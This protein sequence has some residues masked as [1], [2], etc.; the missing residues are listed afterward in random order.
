M[1]YAPPLVYV[2]AL[3]GGYIMKMLSKE[4]LLSTCTAAEPG[5]ELPS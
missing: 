2:T 3:P 4:P 5:T 1:P